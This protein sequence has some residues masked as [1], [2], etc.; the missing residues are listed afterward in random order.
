MTDGI[1]QAAQILLCGVGPLPFGD[2]DKLYAPGLRVL[3]FARALLDADCGLDILEVDFGRA[4]EGGLARMHRVWLDDDPDA[5]DDGGTYAGICAQSRDMASGH[6]VELVHQALEANPYR[7]IVSTTDV[8]N[9]ACARA[10]DKLPLWCDFNG[11]PMAERQAMAAVY[12]SDG[13]LAD[14]WDYVLA[15]L[16]RG[17]QFSTCSSRQRPTLLGELAACGRLNKHTN[18][19]E[20]VHPMHP[21]VIHEKFE[22]KSRAFRGTETP[23]DAFV[24]LWTGGYNTWADVDTLADA[25]L[26]AMEEAPD[27]HYLS[28]GGA[29]AGHDDRSF[30]RFQKRVAQSR[31]A[32]RFHFVGWVPT[33]EVPNYYLEADVAVN[34]DRMNLDSETGCRN[35]IMDWVAAE[36]PVVSTEVCELVVELKAFGLIDACVPDSV[37]ALSQQLLEVYHR[38][39]EERRIKARQAR[40]YLLRSFDRR[41]RYAALCE[42]AKHPRRAPDFQKPA[43][44]IPGIPFDTPDNPLALRRALEWRSV[45]HPEFKEAEPAGL[46]ERLK[47]RL[48]G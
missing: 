45:F 37:G 43:N 42:W 15:T 46:W 38:S 24:V 5:P 19:V 7:A 20:L 32:D 29:I 39:P 41:V 30:E 12:D 47:R 16:L 25:L 33:A 26:L 4:K 40:E 10:C 31:F 36:L 13:G 34:C 9:D 8:M 14:Q 21:A 1:T 17:D 44:P 23:D 3:S 22:A 35:R 2:T 28:T 27:M 18:A 48:K 11:W 6:P